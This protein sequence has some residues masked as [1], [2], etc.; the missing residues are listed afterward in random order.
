MEKTKERENV[1]RLVQDQE[2]LIAS[3]KT[4]FLQMIEQVTT[5]EQGMINLNAKMDLYIKG[6]TINN[7]KRIRDKVFTNKEAVSK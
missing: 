1:L 5:I 7:L 2:E 3:L 4:Q 6:E